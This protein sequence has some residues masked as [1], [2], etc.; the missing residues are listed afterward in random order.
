LLTGILTA[1]RLAVTLS[2]GDAPDGACSPASEFAGL[3]G[4]ANPV[5]PE[6]C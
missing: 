3:D 4:L 1:Y 5:R 6:Q 2:I